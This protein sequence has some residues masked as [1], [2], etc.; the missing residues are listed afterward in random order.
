MRV[1]FWCVCPAAVCDECPCA[2]AAA[3]DGGGEP[4]VGHREAEEGL[5]AADG[6]EHGE[7][8]EKDSTPEEVHTDGTAELCREDAKEEGKR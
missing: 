6:E 5:A 1:S 8:R 4:R 3:E 7:E 2:V